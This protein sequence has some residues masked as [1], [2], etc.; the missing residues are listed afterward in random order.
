DNGL[1]TPLAALPEARV[2]EIRGGRFHRQR[3]AP[4]F[5]GRDL[6]APAAAHLLDGGAIESLGPR[7]HD[8]RLLNLPEARQTA[9]GLEGEVVHV[10]RFGNAVTSI[11][12]ADLEAV[13][14]PLAVAVAGRRLALCR[15]YAD[16]APGSPLALVG[17]SGRL[18]VAVRDGSAAEGLGLER[19]SQVEVVDAGG[20]G[21]GGNPVPPVDV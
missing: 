9:A 7:I 14:A 12:D 4:T 17:S 6:F 3:V 10:D 21:E 20:A 16:V 1:L 19:G 18:E 11:R 13:A 2:H 8:P 5:H 15:T